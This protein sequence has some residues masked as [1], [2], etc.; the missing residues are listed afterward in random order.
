MDDD[1]DD[2]LDPSV[3]SN[4]GSSVSGDKLPNANATLTLGIISI[5]GCLLYALPGLICGIIAIAL[6]KKD[7]EIYKSDPVRF[8]ASYKNAKAGFICGIIGLSLS[9]AYILFLVFF[10]LFAVTA[11]APLT[12]F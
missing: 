4:S 1:F 5:V 7:K 8:D 10:V 12:R 9:A 6:H 11:M 3:K 2:L